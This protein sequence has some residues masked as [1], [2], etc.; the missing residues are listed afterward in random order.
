MR[1]KDLVVG[2]VYESEQFGVFRPV[3]VL[4]EKPWEKVG[5][6]G[7]FRTRFRQGKGNGVAVAESSNYTVD[8]KTYWRPE[9]VQLSKLHPVGTE[10]ARRSE[11][12]RQRQASADH[13]SERKSH[14]K[15]VA[16]RVGVRAEFPY[17]RS[18]GSSGAGY[19]DY[20]TVEVSLKDFE[21]LVRKA[22]AYDD[23]VDFLPVD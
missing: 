13:A 1:R 7:G 8:E 16:G 23:N 15:S 4:D 10:A 2:Q 9:V 12:E 22:A 20:H 3:V 6:S 14:L 5:Y 17:R 18:Y 21:R 19:V 11:Q